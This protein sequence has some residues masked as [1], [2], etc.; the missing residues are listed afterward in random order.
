MAAAVRDADPVLFFEHKGLYA[1]EG[2]GARRRDRRRRSARPRCVREG[3]DATIVALGL[4][5][6]AGA[7]RRRAARRR[8]GIDAEVIDVRSPRPARHADDPAR[9]WRKTGRLFTVEENPQLCGW[10]A[11]IVVD[12]GRRGVLGPRRADRADHHAAHPA[13]G[14][15]QPR[16]RADSERRQDRRRRAS[17]RRCNCTSHTALKRRR[18]MY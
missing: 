13:A 10:G 15:G 3:G 16:G 14:R 9:R 8:D 6:A 1:S 17:A 11:E 7:R 2:R 18:W 4:D 5:G 12:R